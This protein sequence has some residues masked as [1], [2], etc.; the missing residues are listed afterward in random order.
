MT[1][2]LRLFTIHP[3]VCHPSIC[4]PISIHQFAFQLSVYQPSFCSPSIRLFANPHPSICLPTLCLT[5]VCSPSV[6]LFPI[7][8]SVHHPS[9]CSPSV[10]L[11]VALPE[12]ELRCRVRRHSGFATLFPILQSSFHPKMTEL[13]NGA[14][15]RMAPS[16]MVLR[17]RLRRRLQR[18]SVAAALLYH[19][20]S[21]DLPCTRI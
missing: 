6:R 7:R 17:R 12:I 3:S 11:G 16:E 21:Y 13:L 8:P 5:S 18:R 2:N 19:S 10:G 1:T 20:P 4:S 9:I 14:I 15:I